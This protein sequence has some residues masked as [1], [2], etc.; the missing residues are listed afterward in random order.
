MSDLIERFH[1]IVK[2]AV[3]EAAAPGREY[4]FHEAVSVWLIGR[5][6]PEL[7]ELYESES[8]PTPTSPWRPAAMAAAWQA[9]AKVRERIEEQDW[10]RRNL[11]NIDGARYAE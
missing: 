2:Y 5:R 4:R 3:D 6:L 9:V 10:E 11:I 8:I 1:E 7:R